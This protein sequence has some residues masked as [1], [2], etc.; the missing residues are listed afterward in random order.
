MKRADGLI[1]LFDEGT[2]RKVLRTVLLAFA[3]A[4]AL[5]GKRCA[6]SHRDCLKIF[7]SSGLFALGVHLI[8]AAEE[9]GNIHS[10]GAGHAIT[11]FGAEHSDLFPDLL[12]NGIDQGK[13]LFR[14]TVRLC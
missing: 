11:A 7:S 6:L 8:I 1:C 12:P 3:A 2:D 14:Q 13:I 5:R 9:S 10:L 4:D